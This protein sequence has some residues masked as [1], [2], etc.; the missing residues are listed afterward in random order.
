MMIG[1]PFA[2]ISRTCSFVGLP[3]SH[4]VRL[5]VVRL[6]LLL[7]RAGLLF[8]SALA[9]GRIGDVVRRL[10]RFLVIAASLLFSLS[11]SAQKLP[12]GSEMPLSA[13][14]AHVFRLLDQA[15]ILDSDQGEQFQAIGVLLQVSGSAPPCGRAARTPAQLPLPLFLV[16]PL[17]LPLLPLPVLPPL[18]LLPFPSLP[19]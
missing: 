1:L 14:S 3:P 11:A 4:D 6:G 9:R 7:R 5:R 16:L 8:L 10:L 2:A 12:R 13:K 18:P 19:W 17:P 15:W